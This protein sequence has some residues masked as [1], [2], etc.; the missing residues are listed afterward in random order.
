MVRDWYAFRASLQAQ[1][2]PPPVTDSLM[3]LYTAQL[4]RQNH[5]SPAEW[6]S[7]KSYFVQY[8]NAWKNLLEQALQSPPSP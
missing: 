3:Q 5:I 8:P 2:R 1:N 4:L 7:L 6:D